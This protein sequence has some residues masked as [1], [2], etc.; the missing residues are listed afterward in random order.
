MSFS[1]SLSSLSDDEDNCHEDTS[2]NEFRVVI[3]MV[4]Y[5][6]FFEMQ[7]WRE[8]FE[9]DDIDKVVTFHENSSQTDSWEVVM[10]DATIQLEPI[11]VQ[12]TIVLY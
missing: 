11:D 3:T 5:I 2:Q 1:D 7:P 10:R 6:H 12:V 4:P 8:A 9:I